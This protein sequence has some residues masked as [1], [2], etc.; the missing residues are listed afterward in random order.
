MPRMSQFDPKERQREKERSRQSDEQA[1]RSGRVSRE[2]LQVRNSLLGSFEIL[3]S[4]IRLQ[5]VLVS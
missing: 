1:L 4:S 3:D 5:G 2:Q